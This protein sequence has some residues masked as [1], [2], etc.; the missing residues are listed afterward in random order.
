MYT[1]EQIV[2]EIKRIAKNAGTNALSEQEFQLNSTIPMTTVRFHL[3]SWPRALEEAG[4]DAAAVDKE[5]RAPLSED[6][7]LLDLMR[8]F[9]TTGETPTRATITEQGKYDAYHYF[10]RWRSISEAFLQAKKKFPSKPESFKMPPPE[11]EEDPLGLISSS[12]VDFDD[13]MEIEE[14]VVEEDLEKTMV[15]RPHSVEDYREA[16]AKAQKAP[17]VKTREQQK[18]AKHIPQTFKPKNGKNRKPK[19]TPIQFRGLRYAPTD[20]VG[21]IYLFGLVS[22]ELGFTL[23]SITSE[24]PH[25]EGTRITSPDDP[26]A[27]QERVRVVF[28]LKSTDF[29]AR[30]RDE[31]QCDL[32]VC[33]SHNWDDCPIEVL[34][35]KSIIKVLD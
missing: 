28:E 2:R 7:L 35:L 4:L 29:K 14:E 21:V 20:R 3:G 13:E 33:W 27:P 34:E 9:N 8:L 22:Y 1:K 24:Y 18:R 26:S 31:S 17:V 25:A 15:S 11:K 10:K 16:Q 12:G 30:K 32:L 19:G 23:E 5:S 6:D